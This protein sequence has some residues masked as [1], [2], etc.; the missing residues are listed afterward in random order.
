MLTYNLSFASFI[1][2]TKIKF[3]FMSQLKIL[4]RNVLPKTSKP[5]PIALQSGYKI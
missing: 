5:Q 2:E 4:M 1:V 3:P